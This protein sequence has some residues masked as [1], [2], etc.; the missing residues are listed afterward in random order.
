MN[1]E[2]ERKFLLRDGSWREFVKSSFLLR[3]GYILTSGG[4]TV[5]VRTSSGRGYL[6]LKSGPLSDGLSR[7]EFEYEVPLSDAETMLDVLC[8]KPLVEKTRHVIE[9]SGKVWEVDEFS[10]VNE[11]LV[12]V[13]V[14]LDCS[15]EEIAYPEWLGLEVTHDGRYYNSYLVKHPYT[16]WEQVDIAG[17]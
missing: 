13:E 12:I 6:T 4:V 11:G 14:E 17:E 3:Q 15:D 2:T 16:T 9:Y 1:I 5:R 8:M 10:G 7:H